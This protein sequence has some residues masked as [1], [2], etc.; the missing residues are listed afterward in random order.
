MSIQMLGVN[1]IVIQLEVNLVHLVIIWLFSSTIC[2]LLVMEWNSTG[3]TTSLTR[4]LCAALFSFWS[5]QCAC[6]A[7]SGIFFF[8][9]ISLLESMEMWFRLFTL[10]LFWKC[11]EP[12]VSHP[13]CLH[14]HSLFWNFTWYSIYC[15]NLS[16]L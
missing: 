11:N 9:L 5:P 12:S 6:D 2:C 8:L 16:D 15:G 7:W 1:W 4:N 13:M 14:S 3:T 10:E